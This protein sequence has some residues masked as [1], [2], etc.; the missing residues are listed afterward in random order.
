MKR[1]RTFKLKYLKTQKNAGR[2][3]TLK[4]TSFERTVMAWSRVGDGTVTVM[5]QRRYLHCMVPLYFNKNIFNNE[6]KKD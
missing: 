1:S 5:D 6:F 2:F 3:R 4:Y